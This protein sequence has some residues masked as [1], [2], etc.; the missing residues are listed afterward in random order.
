MDNFSKPL[1]PFRLESP[2]IPDRIFF[3]GIFKRSGGISPPPYD[4]LNLSLGVGDHPDNVRANRDRVKKS[5]AAERL[6]SAG[7]VHGSGILVIEE[8]P[9]EDREFPGY[10]ALIT[11]VPGPALMIQLADCQAVMVLDPVKRVA[12]NIHCGWRGN[13]A[14][15]IGKT[16]HRMTERFRSRPSDL[17]AFISPSLGPCCAEFKNWRQELPREFSRYQVRPDYFDLWAVS[18]DQLRRAG[19][20]GQ[21]VHTAAL[22]TKCGPEWFSYRREGRTGRFGAVIGLSKQ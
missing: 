14:D 2:E 13:A 19:V 21:N 9:E 1:T 16:I 20:L 15:I 11:D 4:S 5:L 18:R 8:E 22:C 12:A 17:S 3:H 10:D 7:Q 6:L